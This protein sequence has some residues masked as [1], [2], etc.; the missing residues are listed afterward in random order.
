MMK[1]REE[2]FDE[3]KTQRISTPVT[4]KRSLYAALLDADI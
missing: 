2:A 4:L 3:W 1:T